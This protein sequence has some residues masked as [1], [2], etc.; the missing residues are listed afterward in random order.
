M[1]TQLETSY[2]G[3]SAECEKYMHAW[4]LGKDNPAVL[5]CV[6]ALESVGQKPGFC[7]WDFGTDASYV[8]GVLGIP[9]IGYS[10]MEEHYAHT[11]KDRCDIEKLIKAT[12]GNAAIAYAFLA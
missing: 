5:R 4:A 2:T 12:A 3:I 7:R 11:P 1:R 9:T 6:Q 10:P 8:T